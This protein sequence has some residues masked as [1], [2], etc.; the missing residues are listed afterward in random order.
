MADAIVAHLGVKI[1]YTEI[2]V[3]GVRLAARRVLERAGIYD[4]Q[5]E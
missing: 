1:S 4:V 5:H 3:G 2:P